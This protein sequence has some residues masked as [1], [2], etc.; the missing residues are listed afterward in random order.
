MKK[1]DTVTVIKRSCLTGKAVWFY[2][3]PSMESMRKA[4]FRACKREIERVHNWS[5]RM[6]NCNASIRKLLN[7]CLDGLPINAELSPEQKEAS[8]QLQGIIKRG[9]PCYREFYDH[10]LEEARRKN[11][12]SR[13]WAA[14]RAKK[15]GL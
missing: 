15:F 14:A 3:G 2:R 8:S 1:K 5:H 10:I 7:Q 11:A 9:T 4:Y 6:E 13:R 12:A